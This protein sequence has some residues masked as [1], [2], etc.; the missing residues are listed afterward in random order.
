[1]LALV[2]AV[3]VAAT[4][5]NAAATVIWTQTED[6]ARVMFTDYV[7]AFEVVGVLLLAAVIG[8][9]FV[10]KRERGQGEGAA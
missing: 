9:V 8:A 2:L 6:L 4:D 5:W 1:V 7:F 10:A 3:S